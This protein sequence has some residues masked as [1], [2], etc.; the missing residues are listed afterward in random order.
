VADCWWNDKGFSAHVPVRFLTQRRE[1]REA[2]ARAKLEVKPKI[3]S[4]E[5]S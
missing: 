1:R 4:T 3:R 5:N 2:K